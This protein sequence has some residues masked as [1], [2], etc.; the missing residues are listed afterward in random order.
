M[1]VHHV[2]FVV[3]PVLFCQFLF[4]ASYL[5]G[6]TPQVRAQQHTTVVRSEG[7]KYFSNGYHRLL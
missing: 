6:C 2:I 5:T 7:K 1:K 3:I 4:D